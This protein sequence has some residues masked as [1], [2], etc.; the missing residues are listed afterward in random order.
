MSA[1]VKEPNDIP[2]CPEVL[3]SK[4]PRKNT[5]E[6]SK[7]KKTRKT[8]KTGERECRN[9]N[10]Q[11]DDKSNL[12]ALDSSTGTGDSAASIQ[13]PRTIS[14]Q[15]STIPACVTAPKP[16]DYAAWKEEIDQLEESV[17]ATREVVDATVKNLSARVEALRLAINQMC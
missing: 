12:D 16:S 3:N 4:R 11:V 9:E 13:N 8:G 7:K 5:G 2:R 10:K 15:R 14:S 17:E 1:L 6:T